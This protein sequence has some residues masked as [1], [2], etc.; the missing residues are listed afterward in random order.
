[1]DRRLFLKSGVALAA[2]GAL[3]ACGGGA[4]AVAAPVPPVA[5]KKPVTIEQLGR[6]RVDNYKWMK[7]DRWQEVLKDPSV[8]NPEIRDHLTAE[9]AYFDAMMAGASGLRETLFEEMKARFK[10]DD[11]SVPSP[12]GPYE[13]LRRFN[14]G[15]SQ[16]VLARI[17]RGKEGPEEVL[18]DANPLAEGK[19]F[20]RLGATAPSPDHKMFAYAADEQG[21]EVWSIYIK[22]LATGEVLPNP[23]Q[24]AYGDFAW[25]PDSAWLFW[26]WR[27]DNGRPAKIFRR[28]ARGSAAD[29]VQ[30][31][32]EK[33]TGKFIGVAATNSGGF[34]L[35]GSSDQETSEYWVIP[36]SNPTAAPVLFAERKAGEMYQPVHFDGRWMILTN[37][38]GAVDF[39]IVSAPLGKTDRSAWTDVIPHEPGRYIQ[40]IEAY[41][42]HLVRLERSNALPRIVIRARG[43][44]AETAIEQTEQA[45]ALGLQG[46]YEFDTTVIR[47]DYSSPTTPGQIFDYDMATGAKTL[48]KTQEIPSGHDPANYVAERFMAKAK[49][50][51]EVPVTVLR[52]ASAKLDGSEPVF[53]Y[54]YG[55]YGSTLDANF[56]PSAFSLVNR[57]WIYVLAH[58]RGGADKGW[59]WFEQGRK[60]RKINSFT[61]FVAVAEDLVARKYATRGRIV[62]HGRSAGGMLMGGVMVV[63]PDGLFGGYVAGV[64]FVD[65]LNTISDDTLPLTPPEWP[66]WGNP[67]TDPAAYDYI[68]SYSPYENVSDRPYPPVL[69]TG[70]LSDPRVTYWEPAKYVAQLRDRAPKAGP[71]LL[72]IDMTAGHGGG[73]GRFDR[74]KDTARDFAFAM[75]A[76]GAEE[77]GGPFPV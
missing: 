49:D 59:D 30:I 36:A 12:Y 21:S 39:K 34:I 52:Q 13:Y 24:D 65:V 28:P 77:A 16:P 56:N 60:D 1:M 57:G 43:T 11:T 71:Y 17:P 63:A 27:D 41:A 40:G 44:G 32:E 45:F 67:L 66:E 4:P 6:T 73:G 48:R 50:G 29:D 31:Y 8:L 72:N 76:M 69:A 62:A 2:I 53:L 9:N 47:Y 58:V 25:S 42:N 3:S 46:G 19:A 10:Q 15:Q 68:A 51:A 23:V 33:D 75:K 20:F 37:A 54:G 74:L 70:G 22:D 5:P 18:L 55:A 64:P 38:G 14:A 7:D 61:D 35:I 26:V